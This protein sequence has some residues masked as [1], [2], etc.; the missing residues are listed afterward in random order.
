[1]SAL[2]NAQ[3]GCSRSNNPDL[4]AKGVRNFMKRRQFIQYAGS[5]LA[6]TVGMGAIAAL[7]A[8][9]ERANAQSGGVT[10]QAL[11][12]TC[13]LFS[14]SGRRILVNPFRP[15]GCTKGYRAPN[16]SAD[17]VLIS[18]RLFDEGSIEGL[19]SSIR[20]LDEPG[21]YEF[22][23]APV[24]QVQGIS[25]F[26][27]DV[28]GDRFGINV[29]WKW[30]QGGLNILHM[31]GAAAALTTEQQT[32]AGRPDIAFVPV[33]NGP[34][35]FTPEEAAAAVRSLNPKIVVPTQY[36]TAAADSAQCDIVPID[37]FLQ[38]MQGVPVERSGASLS[39]S[40]SSLPSS[41]KIIVM[42]A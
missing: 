38:L 21:A 41:T 18:S 25:S 26:H 17:L 16:V 29:M 40:S 12:H 6:T 7:A 1:M 42:G 24:L 27:D 8:N 5:G 23:Q 14:G 20:V 13:F 39:L 11:G 9:V 36:R 35:A 37:N 30:T 31:G 33:G 4:I 19:S 15:I 3:V 34:K 28:N 10:I 22:S 32:L 2:K